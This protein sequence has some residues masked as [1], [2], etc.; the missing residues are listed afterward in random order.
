MSQE[1]ENSFFNLLQI[2]CKG[3]DGQSASLDANL[4]KLR[5]ELKTSRAAISA[6]LVKNIEQDIKVLH[7]E[8]HENKQDF[9]KIGATWQRS[10][11]DQPK[12]VQQQQQLNNVAVDFKDSKSHFY[13]LATS[14][15]ILLGIQLALEKV[16]VEA[17]NLVPSKEKIAIKEDNIA[18][19]THREALKVGNK[20]LSLEPESVLDT[21]AET[22]SSV[23]R[24]AADEMLQLLQQIASSDQHEQLIRLLK[25]GVALE[26][27]PAV[28]S[29][30]SRLIESMLSVK[31]SDFSDYLHLLNKQLSD[32]QGAIYKR[33]DIDSR[34]VEG[35]EAADGLVRDSVTNIRDTVSHATEVDVLKKELAVQLDQIMTA[36]DSLKS[37]EQKRKDELLSNFKVLKKRVTDMEKEAQNV[38]GSIA[39]EREKARLDELT[40]LPN[41]TAY[42]EAV[43]HQLAHFKRFQK[44]LV[45]VVCD[46]DRFKLVNDNYGHLAGD[47]VLTLVAKILS[48]GTRDCDFVTRYGGEEFVLLLPETNL[49]SSVRAMD[50]IRRLICR[51]PFNY[52]GKPI[53]ISMSFGL[54][55]AIES[56]T[57]ESFFYRADKALYRAKEMGRNVVCEG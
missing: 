52:R 9:Q 36:M 55:A 31:G 14:F 54:T 38:Q 12:D 26:Q 23:L 44:P 46:L 5:K 13:M 29:E 56:D 27:L 35:R 39:R 4:T 30:I 45:L 37:E 18:F 10:L 17:E 25:E 47:K 57:I 43:K 22:V 24:K 28:I 53:S 21:K 1:A 7:L 15:K 8:R 3:I 16:T 40:Q 49:A 11:I 50:K 19:V 48:Q 33:L 42:T 32:V 51:S 34:S 41:R 20:D 2:M 6:E